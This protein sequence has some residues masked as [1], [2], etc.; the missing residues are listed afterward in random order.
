MQ[1]FRMRVHLN[2]L[3]QSCRGISRR[4]KKGCFSES[5]LAELRG[6]GRPL[7]ILVVCFSALPSVQGQSLVATHDNLVRAGTLNNAT[8]TLRLYAGVGNWRPEGEAGA[9][10][11]VQA[12]GEDGRG[13]QVPGPLVRVPVGTTIDASIRNTLSVPLELHG[14]GTRPMAADQP[15]VIAPGDTRRLT[16]TAGAAGT[17]H[18]WATTTQSTLARRVNID[19]QLSGAFVVDEPGAPADRVFVM[20]YWAAELPGPT[21]PRDPR[22]IYV[23]NG[24]GWPQTQRLTY[25]VGEG[26]RWR[27]INLTETGH[28]MH[29]HGFYFGVESVGNGLQE[30]VTAGG[31]ERRVVTELVPTGGTMRMTWTPERDGNWLFHCHIVGHIAP[32]LTLALPPAPG[33]ASHQGHDATGMAGLVVGITI[34]PRSGSTTPATV[35]ARTL[36]LTMRPVPARFDKADGYG[37]TLDGGSPS[38]PGPT[39][40]LTRGEPVQITLVNE[41]PEATAIHWH[42]MELESYF[43]GV[44]NFSGASGNVTPAIAPGGR[45]EVR[46]TPPRSGT[47]MYHTHSHDERV[48]AK[49]LYGA[50]LV[51]DPGETHDPSTD[52][53]LILGLNGD[54]RERTGLPDG[55]LL[56][57]GLAPQI[58]LKQGRPNRLRLINITANN[59]ALTFV[60]MRLVEMATWKAIAKDGATLPE[61]Q[62]RVGTARQLVSVGET[63]DF[64]LTPTSGAYWIE[65]R[66]GSGAFLIQA[67]VVLA[68]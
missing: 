48:L 30:T 58:T 38:T 27:V 51:L 59:G 22:I 54:V 18:Y 28:P 19:T 6:V 40:V 60:V 43:D 52:H 29:L 53:V 36:T 17:Y 67:P 55:I 62:R 15:I 3:R 14:F 63:Y 7:L 32:D 1:R 34:R 24:R 57:G 26:V 10:V 56:N 4:G 44:P 5:L 65:V 68:R 2:G 47:F 41:L 39:L 42:G 25:D 64:E 8:L 16:F 31:E 13:L 61:S 37:F 35:P 33:A 49:G 46:F 66:R 20:T 9:A 21:P 11:A 50:L 45:F 23:I 12:F